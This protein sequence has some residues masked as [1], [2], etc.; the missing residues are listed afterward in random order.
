[1]DGRVGVAAAREGGG[2]GEEERGAAAA[3]E[4]HSGRIAGL[5]CRTRGK[6]ER[7]QKQS[8]SSAAVAKRLLE[9]GLLEERKE[10]EMDRK[11]LRAKPSWA[12][13]PAGIQSKR[14]ISHALL[15]AHF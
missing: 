6:E 13:K 9:P 3:A 12:S 14:Q 10:K 11:K 1:V 7:R 8:R 4:E 15:M 5:G 2:C